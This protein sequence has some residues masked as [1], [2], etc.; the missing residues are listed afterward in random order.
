MKTWAQIP[1]AWHEARTRGVGVA[2]V[3]QRRNQ[4]VLGR[5]GENLGMSQDDLVEAILLVGRIQ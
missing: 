4:T 2:A 1:L 5:W 3:F